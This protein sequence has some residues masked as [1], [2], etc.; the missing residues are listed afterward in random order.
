MGV[1]A[2]AS[3]EIIA[4]AIVAIYWGLML[5]TRWVFIARPNRRFTLAKIDAVQ[6]RLYAAQQEVPVGLLDDARDIA[7]GEDHRDPPR[8]LAAKRG[9]PRDEPARHQRRGLVKT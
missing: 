3:T 6:H 8:W 7:N 2:G 5:V 4:L 9:H 1:R